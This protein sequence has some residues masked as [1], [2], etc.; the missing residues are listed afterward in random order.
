MAR[1]RG[2]SYFILLTQGNSNIAPANMFGP[3]V[4][5]I[6]Q[7]LKSEWDSASAVVRLKQQPVAV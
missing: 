2:P 1:H 3:M 7:Q 4:T 5:D 6:D